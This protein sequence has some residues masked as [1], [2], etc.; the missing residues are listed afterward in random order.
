VRN[1]GEQP[2]PSD[3]TGAIVSDSL[4]GILPEVAATVLTASSQLPILSFTAYG[5]IES[6]QMERLQI[7]VATRFV[8]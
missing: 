3:V 1:C 8:F 5:K 6:P 2:G 4:P 7:P